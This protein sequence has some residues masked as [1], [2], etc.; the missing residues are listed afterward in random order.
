MARIE[1]H[2]K[3]PVLGII[4]AVFCTIFNL[5]T[6]IMQTTMTNDRYAMFSF[7][8]VLALFILSCINRTA[9]L[10]VSRGKFLFCFSSIVLILIST[11]INK[12]TSIL[13]Y[14]LIMELLKAFLVSQMLDFG[15]YANVYVKTVSY[16]AIISV[17][18]F[19][20]AN[21]S[22]AFVSL[23]RIVTNSIGIRYRS[24]GVFFLLSDNRNTGYVSEPGDWQHYVNIALL[25]EL[26]YLSDV[27]KSGIRKYFPVFLTIA[28]LTTLSPVGIVFTALIW[29]AF[30]CSTSR[31]WKKLI[32][33]IVL[34]TIAIFAVF[35]SSFMTSGLNYALAKLDGSH[36]SSLGVRALSVFSGIAVSI[37]NPLFGLGFTKATDAMCQIFEQNGFIYDQTSTFSAFIAMFGIPIALLFTIPYLRCFIAPIRNKTPIIA[38]IM[39]I[40]GLFFSINN[41]R[42][43][44]ELTYYFFVLYGVSS[45]GDKYNILVKHE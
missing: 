43:I 30:V 40:G 44:F 42:F 41:E 35:A 17:I 26:F 27:E 16:L 7:V 21:V 9:S 29:M 25:L 15:E 38:K 24:Y 28:S 1:T 12:E 45:G 19:V 34:S 8:L 20:L 23:G 37:Q 14:V 5:N 36:T 18:G 39:F 10:Q 2:R 6:L 4:A 33:N 11:L 13:H 3:P 22:D 31:S 32:R